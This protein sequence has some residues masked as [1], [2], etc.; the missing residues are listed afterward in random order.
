M[1]FGQVLLL[2]VSLMS[3]TSQLKDINICYVPK[4]FSLEQGTDLITYTSFKPF[5][6]PI[7]T[8]AVGA[9]GAGLAVALNLPAAPLLGA[10]L[11]TAALGWGGVRLSLPD[12]F[13][14]A[15]LLVIGLSLGSGFTRDMLGDAGEYAFSLGLLSISIVVSMLASSWLLTR[16][17]RQSA[18][19]ALLASAPGTL[20]LALAMAAE[21]K[22]DSTTVI[23]LQSMRLLMLAAFLPLLVSFMGADGSGGANA[24]QVLS[25][26]MLGLL[27]LLGILLG[28]VFG[29]LHFPA[30]FLL[31][32]MV[33]SA[34]AHM[35]EWAHGL[36]PAMVIFLGFALVGAASG[37]RFSNIALHDLVKN[38][39]AAFASVAVAAAVSA[40]FAFAASAASGLP[41]AQIWVAYAPG[42][43]EAMAAIGLAL[44]FDPAF[45][46]LHHLFRI[47]LLIAILPLFVKIA[48]NAGQKNAGP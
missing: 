1:G 30:P 29:R 25:W 8:L 7:K 17:W 48:T 33:V 16:Y 42:G 37:A 6:L 22:G 38:L 40:L 36:P 41:L 23:C 35:A 4:N 32:G 14:D 26:T 10:M 47:S 27:T 5:I 20:S 12:R 19:T 34:I 9:L 15:G 45:V 24:D 46:A 39:G 31:G 2:K 43:V 3:A 28:L 21:G 11:A 13:R 18:T 44:G